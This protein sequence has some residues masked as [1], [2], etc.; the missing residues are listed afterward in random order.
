M[1]GKLSSKINLYKFYNWYN[2][3]NIQSTLKLRSWKKICIEIPTK[4]QKTGSYLRQLKCL[5]RN[6]SVTLTNVLLFRYLVRLRHLKYVIELM[7]EKKGFWLA[8]M[9]CKTQYVYHPLKNRL[10][11]TD[12]EVS[13]KFNVKLQTLHTFAK[14]IPDLQKLKHFKWISVC[15]GLDNSLQRHV[16]FQS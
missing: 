6:W 8:F 7:Q 11:L 9:R 2:T 16:V 4:G 5:V 1:G 12:L 13:F 3:A 15:I 10:P 14:P